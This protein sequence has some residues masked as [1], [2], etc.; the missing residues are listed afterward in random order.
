MKITDYEK[1]NA[2]ADNNVFLLDGDNGTKTI[3]AKD[4][5]KAL[6]GKLDAGDIMNRMIYETDTADIL[7]KN[8]YRDFN[9]HIIGRDAKYI[10]TADATNV[11]RWYQMTHYHTI[12]TH[13][14]IMAHPPT[15]NAIYG[16]HNLGSVYTDKDKASVNDTLHDGLFI[17]D[18]WF[19]GGIKWRIVDFDYFYL[20]TCGQDASRIGKHH[21][22]I[23][24]DQ[25]LAYIPYDKEGDYNGSYASAS[26]RTEL[27]EKALP[28]AEAAFGAN[29]ILPLKLR[30]PSGDNYQV[31]SINGK[32]FIPSI[33]SILG[34]TGGAQ[35]SYILNINSRFA[36]FNT[37][38][39]DLLGKDASSGSIQ[40]YWLIEP[41]THNSGKALAYSS[42]DKR[43]ATGQDPKKN[44]G[45]RP[46]FV[47]VGV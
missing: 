35:N 22:V 30:V 15:R 9:Y 17:G 27:E 31:T 1:V 21:C 25:V 2:L 13:L 7:L 41:D 20:S 23:M 45:V 42:N 24:P 44:L 16:N 36:L 46:F 28:L 47:L 10:S 3:L 19:I 14:N 29:Y 18:Y 43:V 37:S 38:S 40:N 12:F 33:D 34:N 11:Q 26:I 39:Q 32:M 8:N 4:L 6:I 5:A